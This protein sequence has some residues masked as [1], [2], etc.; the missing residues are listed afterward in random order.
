MNTS[1]NTNIAIAEAEIQPGSS[2][3][4]VCLGKN[5][6][7]F[8]DFFALTDSVLSDIIDFMMRVFV[9]TAELKPEVLSILKF[10]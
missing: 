7:Y 5:M 1:I 10:F 3:I 9:I 6:E 2:I 8:E 4:L